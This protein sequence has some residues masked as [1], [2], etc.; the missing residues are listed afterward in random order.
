MLLPAIGRQRLAGDADQVRL[1]VRAGLPV[2][3]FQISAGAVVGDAEGSSDVL[4]A[5]SG[6]EQHGEAGLR[7]RQSETPLQD[8][9]LVCRRGQRDRCTADQQR[10]TFAAYAMNFQ[11]P[12]R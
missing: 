6:H 11:S 9:L 4:D 3:A 12:C 5:L 8:I 7:V 1:T 2:D 10:I